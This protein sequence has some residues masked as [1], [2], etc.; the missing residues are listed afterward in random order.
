M[1][2]FLKDGLQTVEL[3]GAGNGS[4]R[5]ASNRSLPLQAKYRLLP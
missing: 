2:S 5:A 3:E 1:Q 4:D